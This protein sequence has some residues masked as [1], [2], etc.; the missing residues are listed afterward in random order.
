[1]EDENI[2]L[3]H[4]LTTGNHLWVSLWFLSAISIFMIFIFKCYLFESRAICG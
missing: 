1:M 3:A 4:N 2:K